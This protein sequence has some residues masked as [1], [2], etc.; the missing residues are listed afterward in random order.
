MY[1]V[2][3]HCSN[4]SYKE[5]FFL[6]LSSR[7]F[8]FCLVSKKLSTVFF[9]PLNKLLGNLCLR[10]KNSV[11]YIRNKTLTNHHWWLYMQYWKKLCVCG[12]RLYSI[13]SFSI[14]I[15]FLFSFLFRIV[16]ISVIPH[17]YNVLYE[18]R[19]EFNAFFLFY[20]S[21]SLFL[22]FYTAH[23]YNLF[24]SLILPSARYALFPFFFFLCILCSFS[25]V[26]RMCCL[27]F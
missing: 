15:F 11:E 17:A 13:L 14:F 4:R 20:F 2:G 9:H 7:C 1:K 8:F 5:L 19:D 26:I 10:K 16:Q 21:L 24:S 12:Q 6:F 27:H 18:L 3:N 23:W 22:S 25:S